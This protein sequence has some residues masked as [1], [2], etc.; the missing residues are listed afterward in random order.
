MGCFTRE[1]YRIK[2]QKKPSRSDDDDMEVD[3][4]A[5]KLKKFEWSGRREGFRSVGND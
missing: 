5:N 1:G 2:I 3:T 4:V